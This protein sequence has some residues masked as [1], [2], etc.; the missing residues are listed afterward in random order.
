[1]IQL[2][3]GGNKEYIIIIIISN[4]YI[5]CLAFSEF[6]VYVV[7]CLSLVWEIVEYNTCAYEIEAAVTLL[8][9]ESFWKQWKGS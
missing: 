3:N 7:R 6:L 5:Y 4:I 8:L 2:E 9:R 1:M